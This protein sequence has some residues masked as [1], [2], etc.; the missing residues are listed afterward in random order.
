MCHSI[1]VYMDSLF[2]CVCVCE[3]QKPDGLLKT[4]WFMNTY[5]IMGK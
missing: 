3:K 2:V 5:L 4:S 1:R